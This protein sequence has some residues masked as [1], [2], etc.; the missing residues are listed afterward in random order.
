MD[1]AQ[2][3]LAGKACLVTGATGMA[4]AAARRFAAE[5]ASVFVLSLLAEDCRSLAEAISNDGGRAAWRVADL[6]DEDQAVAGVAAAVEAFGRIDGLFAVAGG[7][8]RRFGDGPAHGVSLEAWHRTMDLNATPAFLAARE[9]VR[10]MI[11][12][13]PGAAGSRGALVLMGSVAAFHPSPTRFETAAYAASKGAID[14]LG[15]AMAAYY[16]PL[17]I[18]VNVLA[19]ATV[20][21]PMARRAADDP[22][23][24]DYV[25]WKQPLAGGFMPP[26]DVASAALYLLS[27]ES[28]FVTGQTLI[29]DAGWS[30]TGDGPPG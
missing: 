19:P 29:V 25:R 1:P 2:G 12:Q 28:R 30:V 16:A 4:G 7:S 18:R 11:D 27:D 5:G 15:R 22:A 20:D 14:S 13:E 17:G 10:V 24:A 9:V 21:T 3:R 8:G 6:T 23:T 26:E